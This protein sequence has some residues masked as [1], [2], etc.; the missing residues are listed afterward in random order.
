MQKIII[1][2][3]GFGGVRA[4]L[5]LSKYLPNEKIILINDS[6][7]HCYHADLYEVASAVLKKEKIIDFKNLSGTISIPLKKIF[8]NKNVDILVDTITKIDL[9]ERILSTKNL[10]A[11]TYDF[12]VLGLG[13]TTNYYN[14]E[15][16][17]NFSHPLKTAENALNIR[18]DLEELIAKNSRSTTVVIAGG[19]YTGC[20]TAGQLVTFLSSIC[21]RYSIDKSKI[22]IL[23]ATE[24]VL[25]GMPNWSQALALK[26]L[27][28]LGVEVRLQSPIKKVGYNKIICDNNEEIGFDYLIWTAG[29]IGANLQDQIQGVSFTKRKRIATK[30]DLSLEKYANVF[31]IGDLAECIDIKRG[32]LVSATAWAAIEQGSLVAKNI[33]AKIDNKP[34]RDYMPHDSV[35]V[36]PIGR[37]FALSNFADLKISGIIGW[38]LKRIIALKYFLSILPMFDAIKT[39]GKGVT[40]YL[41]ND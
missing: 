32:C 30:Q 19:G 39:W 4:A 34:T 27:K 13:S 22:I 11:L 9:E 15:G 36:V 28:K 8:K 37:K 12:L 26:Q 21:K 5:D 14:I 41:S 29:N 6:P 25:P 24:S 35:F 16:A 3:A 18:N 33:A 23:E 40:I 20:E 1:A 31:V 17:Q 10:K 7:Y 38:S 2:G